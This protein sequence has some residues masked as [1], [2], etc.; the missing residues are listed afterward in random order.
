MFYVG[1]D[2]LGGGEQGSELPGAG[3]VYKGDSF[4]VTY[5]F[6]HLLELCRTWF[7]DIN[8]LQ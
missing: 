3:G 6:A 5:V 7:D 1:W 2:G 8:V 4:G